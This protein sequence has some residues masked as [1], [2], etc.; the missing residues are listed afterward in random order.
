MMTR[1]SGL[2][3]RG[4]QAL[5]GGRRLLHGELL[6]LEAGAQ[7]AADLHLVVD[8]ERD[9]ETA[10]SYVLPRGGLLGDATAPAARWST[11]L[12]LPAPSLAASIVP[13]HAAHERARDPQTEARAGA[14]SWCGGPR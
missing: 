13:P 8:D 12:P 6:E 4:A 1:S 10:Y 5:G 9:R 7:E 3:G 2:Q 14:S 11:S